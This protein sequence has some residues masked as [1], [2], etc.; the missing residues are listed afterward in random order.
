MH[1]GEYKHRDPSLIREIVET[2]PFAAVMVNGPLGP[3][4]ALAPLTYRTGETEN[5]AIQFHLALINPI[6][7]SMTEGTLITVL[8][9]GPGSGI[10]PSWYDKSFPTAGSDRSQTA[11]TYNYLSLVLQGELRHMDDATLQAQIAT[12]VLAHE[13]SSGWQLDELAPN[14]WSEWRRQIRGFHFEIGQFD[15]TAKISQ[16]DSPGDRSGV[17]AGLRDRGLLDDQSMARIVERYDGT[18]ESLKAAIR[19]L[20]VK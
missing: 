16:G 10:S 19:S 13:P 11:P 9:Q 15:L 18:P 5:G 20:H 1:Y 7:P 8:V 2:F 6:T 4:V 12:L 17:A 14:L 3:R